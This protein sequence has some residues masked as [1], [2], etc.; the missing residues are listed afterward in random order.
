MNALTGPMDV[1]SSVDRFFDMSLN[2]IVDDLRIFEMRYEAVELRRKFDRVAR[3]GDFGGEQSR[4][5]DDRKLIVVCSLDEY[6]H[7][8]SACGRSFFIVACE[9]NAV[10]S[11][12]ASAK[13][14]L[15]LG[16]QPDV[17]YGIIRDCFI[18]DVL[19]ESRMDCVVYRNGR[20]ATL[21]EI[22]EKV[23]ENGVLCVTD[24]GFNVIEIAKGSVFPNEE[25]CYLAENRVYSQHEIDAL[26]S[27]IEHVSQRFGI[28]DL[29]PHGRNAAHSLHCPIFIQG[30]YAY[31]V[32][33]ATTELPLTNGM[34]DKFVKLSRRVAALGEAAWFSRS[35]IASSCHKTLISLINGEK[36][37]RAEVFDQLKRANIATKAAYR[38]VSIYLPE[39]NEFGVNKKI[40]SAALKLN[41]GNCHVFMMGGVLLVLLFS[42]TEGPK[43]G[44]LSKVIKGVTE[45]L[46]RPFGVLS[47][48]SQIFL[49]I[50]DISY[51]YR[52]C[53]LA[54]QNRMLAMES[55]PLGYS[56]LA[57]VPWPCFPFDHALPLLSVGRVLDEDFIRFA[58]SNN[59]LVR[60]VR[61]DK[62]FESD[63]VDI[64]WLY[65]IHERN[66]TRTAEAAHVHRNTVLYQIRKLEER[67]EIDL[68]SPM[69]RMRIRFDFMYS[70]LRKTMAAG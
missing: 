13:R 17:L 32:T 28:F 18:K 6:E 64:L 26:K 20:M 14:I 61:R 41:D 38:L 56:S 54:F 57:N 63:A 44:S 70:R 19:W 66:A 25:Y 33:Y 23:F 51:A 3:Y 68:D 16:V 69:V 67:Y 34:R 42:E 39:S 36:K 62:G 46:Y 50:K 60:T 21:L 1:S 10:L 4:C 58:M 48:V 49:D 7:A 43:G 8:K 24:T 31:H 47:S 22:G 15:V 55:F 30:S 45:C 52:Q 9:P 53:E 2:E 35:E 40:S 29:E 27:G 12:K 5:A 65:L 11:E 59:N 37:T